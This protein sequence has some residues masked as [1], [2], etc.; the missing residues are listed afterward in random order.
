[1]RLWSKRWLCWEGVLH[2]GELW[3]GRVI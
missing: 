3:R 2:L 1:M